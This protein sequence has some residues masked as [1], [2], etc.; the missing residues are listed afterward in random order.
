M[1]RLF[2]ISVPLALY[3]RRV[4]VVC[5]LLVL[6]SFTGT[7]GVSAKAPEDTGAGPLFGGQWAWTNNTSSQT[8]TLD[9]LP[10]IAED[11]TATWCTNCVKVEH[12]LEDLENN[13]EIK[14]YHFHRAN[15]HEDPFGS[16]NTEQHFDSRYNAGAPP[17]V[18]FNGTQKQIGSTANGD[19][20]EDDYRSL[21]GQSLNLG[22]GNTTLSWSS[23]DGQTGVVSWSA[24][25]NMEQF[26]EYEMSVN[27]W[28]VEASAEFT[29]GSNGEEI[30]PS[31]VTKIVEVGN[32]SSGTATVSIPNSYDGDDM[33]VHLMYHFTPI[34][35][36]QDTGLE[37]TSEDS[38]SSSLPSI[39]VVISLSC[40][41]AAAIFKWDN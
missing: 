22:S 29:E 20:L 3:M 7:S 39:S 41:I 36:S 35:T 34:E 18:V 5:C 16:D 1:N 9:S 21:I 8:T 6:I 13:G 17:I 14:K 40:I 31:I 2:Q 12:V 11:Y 4:V 33:Q 38:D 19:S 10:S 30:Y 15:D 32:K 23:Q 27:V 24:E 28:F 25:L 37:D 26:E